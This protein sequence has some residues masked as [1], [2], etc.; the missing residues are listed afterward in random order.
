MP[1][2]KQIEEEHKIT[3]FMKAFYSDKEKTESMR[4]QMINRE[5][6]LLHKGIYAES[7]DREQTK[8]N[9]VRFK[10]LQSIND[11]HFS[12]FKLLIQNDKSY[13]VYYSLAEYNGPIP[14]VSKVGMDRE[15]V[16]RNKEV[17][18][19]NHWKRMTGYD[20]LI[21]IDSEN[22]DYIHGHVDT[23]IKVYKY[24]KIKQKV[25]EISIRFSGCGFHLIVPFKNIPLKLKDV[26]EGQM[27]N[28]EYKYRSIYTNLNKI[29][30]HISDLFGTDIDT[31]LSDSRRLCKCPDTLVWNAK[32]GKHLMRSAI[33]T[34][35]ELVNFDHKKYIVQIPR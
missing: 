11:V 5:G 19:Y 7:E 4:Q 17:W 28:P 32:A 2:K 24:L 23:A 22:I 9:N 15:T 31:G 3:E 21:D 6:A 1:T 25:Q 8:S 16:Q 33:I 27:F 35:D 29:N 13:N 18:N 30:K 34:Y 20:W 14:I 12:L 26:D 10:I